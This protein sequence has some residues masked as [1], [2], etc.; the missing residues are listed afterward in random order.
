MEATKTRRLLD[1]KRDMINLVLAL[2][3]NKD[4]KQAHYEA[5]TLLVETCRLLLE[6]PKITYTRRAMLVN[7]ILEAYE[8]S[9]RYEH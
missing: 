6:K 9:T 1:V 5:D 2:Q 8:A 4:Y 3:N 7:Q